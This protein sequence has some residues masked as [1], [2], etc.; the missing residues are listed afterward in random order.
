[1]TGYQ[2]LTLADLAKLL[3]DSAGEGTRRRLVLEFLEEFQWEPRGARLRLVEEEPGPT[4]DEHWDVLL[5]GLAQH[6]AAQDGRGGPAWA[7]S[8]TLV[9]WW[10]PDDTPAGRADALVH[11][12]ASLRRRGVLI[13]AQDLRRV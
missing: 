10:F 8:R 4:G 12:P 7:E 13:A 5:A 2:P 9:T 1:M 11:A 3:A 6:L